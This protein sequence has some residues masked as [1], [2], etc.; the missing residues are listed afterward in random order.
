MEEYLFGDRGSPTHK[1]EGDEK[2]LAESIYFEQKAE[3]LIKESKLEKSVYKK[4]KEKRKRV[5]GTAFYIPK[6]AY[7]V[8]DWIR[9]Y[10][11]KNNK[12]LPKRFS[13]M[14]SEQLYAIYFKL[15]E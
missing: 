13:K 2:E 6:H 7:E 5:P 1:E 12:P 9:E 10:C 8:R 4:P 11:E 14:R 3:K 15:M